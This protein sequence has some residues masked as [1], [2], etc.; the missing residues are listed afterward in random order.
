MSSQ[1]YKK[2]KSVCAFTPE[3]LQKLKDS[4]FKY[5]LIKTYT[6]D[7]RQ[8]YLSPHYMILT[9][10]RDFSN[11]PDNQGIYESVDSGILKEWSLSKEKDLVVL[12]DKI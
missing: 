2:L 4:G 1:G 6:W 7:R 3:Y 10:I 5:V 11:N 9:P 12:A 8:D